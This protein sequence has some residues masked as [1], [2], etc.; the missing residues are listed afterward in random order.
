[1]LFIAREKK[2][3]PQKS[4]YS[5]SATSCSVFKVTGEKLIESNSSIKLFEE[6]FW[7]KLSISVL[8]LELFFSLSNAVSI[9]DSLNQKWFFLVHY[10]MYNFWR[11]PACN[12]VITEAIAFNVLFESFM[13]NKY[14]PSGLN[15]APLIFYLQRKSCW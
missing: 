13:N 1:M 9:F 15:P 8:R 12:Y 3:Y 7:F 5:Y 10:R 6:T 4:W 2:K 11:E 14:T